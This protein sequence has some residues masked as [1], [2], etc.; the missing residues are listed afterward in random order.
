MTVAVAVPSPA[1]S[2]I[3]SATSLTNG[4]VTN[5]AVTNGAVTNGAVT[6]GAVLGG[7]AGILVSFGTVSLGPRPAL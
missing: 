1:C 7:A 3:F 6:N 4:A 2:P 5:G